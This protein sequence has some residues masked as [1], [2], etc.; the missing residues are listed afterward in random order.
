MNYTNPDKSQSKGQVPEEGNNSALN[1]SA[2]TLVKAGPGRLMR[3][4]V[5]TAGSAVGAVHDS[6]T[7]AGASSANQVGTIPNTVGTTIFNWPCLAGIV[8]K[9]GT[10]Q[11][12]SISFA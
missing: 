8:Y 10:G 3:G 7:I 12:V 4:S 1:L 6:A 11:A 5:I 9:V 2:D